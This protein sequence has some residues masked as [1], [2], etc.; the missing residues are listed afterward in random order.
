MI[1]MRISGTLAVYELAF[2]YKVAMEDSNDLCTGNGSACLKC[3][4]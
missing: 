3:L 4:A 2:P 1:F